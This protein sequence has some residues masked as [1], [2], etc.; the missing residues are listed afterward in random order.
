EARLRVVLTLRADFYDRPLLHPAFAAVF[1]P[2]VVNVVPM[3]AQELEAAVI[4][5]ARR[6]GVEVEPALRAE[7][8]ADT[9]N[10]PGSL[11]L[12]QYALTE[13][14][15]RRTG[16]TLTRAGYVTLGGLRGLLSR[17]AESIYLGLDPDGQRAT[18]QVFLRLVRTGGG[19]ADS[20][21][22]V[23]LS[24]LGDT[25]IDSVVLSE[26]LTAFSRGRLLTFDRDPVSGQATIE[27]AHEA[28]LGEWERLASW[29]D[30]HRA[31]LRRHGVLVAAAEEWELSGH[32]PD[33]LL[34][35]SRLAEFEPWL[36][37]GVLQLSGRERAFLEAGVERRRAAEEAER[38]RLATQRRSER[39]ARW[40][41]AGLAVVVFLLA[42][43]L[44][45]AL[46]MG[47]T[48]PTPQVLLVG[49]GEGVVWNQV[50]S[51]FDRAVADF[52]VVGRKIETQGVAG[53][54]AEAA[55]D[56]QAR[57]ASESGPAL[58]IAFDL[59]DV[60][61]VARDF[62]SVRYLAFNSFPGEM[63][64]VAYAWFR[65]WEGAFLAGAAAARKTQTRTIGVVGGW[66][67]AP[68]WGLVAG[69]EAG[70][71]RVDPD[72]RVLVDYLAGT[73]VKFGRFDDPA[74]GEAA[75]RGQFDQ[76]ADIVLNAAGTSGLGIIQAAAEMSS[77]RGSQLWAIGVDS[78]QYE[79]VS[80]LPG[81]TQADAWRPHI[82]TSVIKR[83]DAVAYDAIGDV[84]A[85]T[86]STDLLPFD[87]ASGQVDISYSGGFIDDLRSNLDAFKAQVV[88]GEIKVPC[89]P[90]DR[91][92]VV[93]AMA[94][95]GGATLEEALAFMCR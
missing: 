9:A 90:D 43:G 38:A 7:L 88:D 59:V 27:V 13:L 31:V 75:A 50:E 36:A 91:L 76:G 33:Y 69:Y 44:T 6:V 79:T 67:F 95:E 41:F 1:N 30:R 2:S 26:V 55:L 53:A 54:P 10:R 93:R 19:A 77:E 39:R 15:D 45:Y 18:M 46:V 61:A 82:L 42:G 87:L 94:A 64:N 14:F 73:D 16:P 74:A 34:V 3:T 62:P 78:D 51:G 70:A 48:R 89:V 4:E 28:L 65:D 25:G 80:H 22:R 24:E 37:G 60:D 23:A 17:R 8:V 52:D 58:V 11:P 12:L 5:P 20:R 40:R 29:I 47:L 85:G 68:I 32:D 84:A 56:G 66:D 49:L 86:F 57:Q 83:F 21:R 35:G 92:D 81:V 72:I 63:P 71:R